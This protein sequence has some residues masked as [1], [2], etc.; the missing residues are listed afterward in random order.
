MKEKIV[1]L[2]ELRE[3]MENYISRVEKGDSFVVVRKSKAVFK[4]SP[5]NDD[6]EGVWETVL[7]FSKHKKGGIP[8]LELLTQIKRFNEQNR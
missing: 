6:Q 4:V 7:D 5:V 3:N 8:A 1:G 2:K